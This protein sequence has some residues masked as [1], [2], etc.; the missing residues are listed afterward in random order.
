[1]EAFTSEDEFFEES[2]AQPKIQEDDECLTTQ[3]SDSR[4]SD[5]LV[6]E[7][8]DSADSVI[9]DLVSHD[10]DAKAFLARASSCRAHHPSCGILEV[11][12]LLTSSCLGSSPSVLCQDCLFVSALFKKLSS[13]DKSSRSARRSWRP[14]LPAIFEVAEEDD[15]IFCPPEPETSSFVSLRL[16]LDLLQDSSPLKGLIE[17]D[18][19]TLSLT[20]LEEFEILEEL[21]TLVE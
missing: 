18:D 12:P 8:C 9:H 17:E 5:V 19:E 21:H 2:D 16:A 10:D 13:A 15:D 11:L 20:S 1:M 3:E 14:S 6:G 7:S 4:W